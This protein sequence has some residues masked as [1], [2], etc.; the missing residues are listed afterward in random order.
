MVAYEE[1]TEKTKHFRVDKIM[2]ATVTSEN[3]IIQKYEIQKSI[4]IY[5]TMYFGMYG[6]VEERVT[7]E[8]DNNLIGVVIDRFGTDIR[9]SKCSSTRFSLCVKISVSDQ[10]FGWIFSLG[11]SA[12]IVSPNWVVENFIALKTA[13]FKQY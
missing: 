9:I 11:E 2:N 3:R 12:R 1:A 6:G 13:V 7:I 10:F 8:F 5:Q 4:G